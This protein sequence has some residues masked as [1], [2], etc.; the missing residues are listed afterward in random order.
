MASSNPGTFEGDQQEIEFVRWFNKNKKEYEK[1]I[2]NFHLNMNKA[3]MIRVTTKQMSMLSNRKVFT[4]SDAYLINSEDRFLIDLLHKSDYYM[5]EDILIKS[6]INYDIIRFSGIS[7]KLKNSNDFQIL[8]VGPQSFKTLFGSYELG[9]GASL[10]CL[11]EDELKK[12]TDLINGWGSNV[13][14]MNEFFHEFTGTTIDFEKDKDSCVKI[15]KY[16]VSQITKVINESKLLQ[17]KIFNGKTLYE[18]PYTAWYF[19]QGLTLKNL[20]FIPYYITTGSGR[21]KGDYTIVLKPL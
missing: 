14:K 20:D 17:E 18:E 16:S 11:R 2:L 4:R 13:N 21:S 3:W 10:F 15:K 7:I 8:K 9:A 6:N 19:T 5:D 12:N 1:F